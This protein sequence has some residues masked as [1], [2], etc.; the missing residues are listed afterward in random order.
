MKSIQNSPSGTASQPPSGTSRYSEIPSSSLASTP[1]G[2]MQWLP[3]VSAAG[4]K[5]LS[6]VQGSPP[7]APHAAPAVKLVV[8]S[9][10]A[11]KQVPSAICDP[12]TAPAL[13][14]PPTTSADS[15]GP[16]V[17]LVRLAAISGRR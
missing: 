3:S 13:R 2:L 4:L 7:V 15:P 12:R 10:T 1:S 16:G 8:A 9:S 6:P 17:A 14:R 5:L 11:T